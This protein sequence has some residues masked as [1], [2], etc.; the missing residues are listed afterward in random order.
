MS[1]TEKIADITE[2]IVNGRDDAAPVVRPYGEDGE[3]DEHGMPLVPAK[4]T[5]PNIPIQAGAKVDDFR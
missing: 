4:T 5:L 2:K 1:I 3:Y